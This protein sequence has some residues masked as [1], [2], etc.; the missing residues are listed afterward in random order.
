MDDEMM[1]QK[2][3]PEAEAPVEEA[4]VEEAPAP[5]APAEEAPVEE[6]PAEEAPVEQEARVE[7]APAEEAP[8]EQLLEAEAEEKKPEPEEPA[9]EGPAGGGAPSGDPAPAAPKPTSPDTIAKLREYFAKM[10][11][12]K[13]QGGDFFASLSVPSYIRDWFLMRFANEDGTLNKEFALAKIHNIVPDR[14]QWPILVDQMINEGKDVK[15]LARIKVKTDITKGEIHF[16]L[17]DYDVDFKDTLIQ[18]VD[19]SKIKDKILTEDEVWGV[20]TLQYRYFAKVNKICL[21]DFAAFRPYRIDTDL[22]KAASSHF[23]VHEWIDVLLGAMDYNPAGYPDEEQKLMMLTRLLPFVQKRLNL[24]ELAPKGTGKSYVFSSVSKFGWLSTGGAMTRA[25][26]FYDMSKNLTGLVAHYDYV[27]LDEVSTIRFGDISEMQGA[28][29]GY[30]E[31][32]AF[33]VGTKK[34]TADAGLIFL[35]NIPKQNMDVSVNMFQTLP[36]LF[37]DSALVD[38]IHGFIE[39]WKIP[40]MDEKLKARGWALN[41][42]YFSEILHALREDPSYTVEV[43]TR[44]DAGKGDFRDITAIKRIAEAYLKLLFPYVSEE[45]PVS[46]EDFEK[47]CLAPAIRMRGIIKQQL[48]IM[49]IEYAEKP[50]AEVKMKPR[51]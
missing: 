13:G 37:N 47:Y 2:P 12:L 50:L 5:E 45:H 42:E 17:P 8:Q 34:A 19:W 24:I 20:V 43:N 25:K 22:Y 31:Q 35:G 6:A 15:F 36:S 32:G 10:V 11:V 4:P 46:D 51:S 28:M 48:A 40:R 30:L 14:K 1:M 49:D 38:R 16:A 27:A 39:G 29:K 7:E 44:L 23:D 41:T 3:A 21:V 26:L 18:P 9:P 33:T